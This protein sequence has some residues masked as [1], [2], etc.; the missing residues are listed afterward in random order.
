M[1]KRN[2]V[3]EKIQ[4]KQKE[5]IEIIE[6][7]SCM[8]ID[9]KFDDGTIITNA[10]YDHFKDGS[11]WNPYS[12]RVYGIGYFGIGEYI[13]KINGKHTKCYKTWNGMLQRCYSE[14]L[15]KKYPSYKECKVCDEWLC[16]QTFAKWYEDNYV[17]YGDTSGKGMSL[18]KDILKKGNKIYSPD[19]CIFVD[20]RINSLFTT[21]KINRGEYPIGVSRYKRDHNTYVSCLSADNKRITLGYSKTVYEAFLIYKEAKEEYIKKIADEYMDK[22]KNFPHK[23]YDAMYR[24]EIE[25]TD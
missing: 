5:N 22:Y 16:Y 24:W 14:S 17:E 9:V 8:D 11:I 15:H 19:T 18:D 7:R 20:Q 4:N 1:I 21:N 25:I 10:R 6:Y 13:C 12:K 3:G 2:R 23:L